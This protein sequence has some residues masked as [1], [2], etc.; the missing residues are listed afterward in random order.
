MGGVA[1]AQSATGTIG[2]TGTVTLNCVVVTGGSGSAFSGTIALGEL[3]DPTTGYLLGSL[4]GASPSGA[5]IKS[6]QVNC[7][8]GH[9][10]IDLKAT[11]LSNASGTALAGY[12]RNID[13]TTDLI[14]TKSDSST[15]S[16]SYTTAPA[17]PADTTGTLGGRMANAAGN[18]VVQIHNLSAENGATSI[19][20]AGSFSS[21][22]TV[23]ISP[24]T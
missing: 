13:Y 10:S 4:S 20:E 23:A 14:L 21:T 9:A 22:I 1:H 15:Q 19:L 18:V 17:L 11:R 5:E 6:F 7:N 2:V 16:F 8:G 3:D 12:S 24:I